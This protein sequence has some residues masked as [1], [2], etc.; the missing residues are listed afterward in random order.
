CSRRSTRSPKRA[1]R[2]GRFRQGHG[3]RLGQER[4]EALALEQAPPD[5][6]RPVEAELREDLAAVL[7]PPVRAR[8]ELRSEACAERVITVGAV[9][10]TA[11]DELRRDRAVPP[12]LLQAEDDVPA[13][14]R[15]QPVE[16]T[17][18]A[19]RDP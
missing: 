1:R 12:V 15:A 2:L 13:A 6:A 3:C 16:L 18:L 10:H 9:E 7:G 17:A 19:E 5:R 8:T 11:N 4:P 14:E